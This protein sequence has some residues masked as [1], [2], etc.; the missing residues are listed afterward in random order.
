[1][2]VSTFH[3][4]FPVS[5]GPNLIAGSASGTAGYSNDTNSAS[6]FNTP[7]GIVRDGAGNAYVADQSNHAIRKITPFGVVTTF[8]GTGSG[9]FVNGNGTSA[10]FSN[11]VALAIDSASNIYVADSS[12]NA[13]RKIDS[14]ANVTTMSFVVTGPSA[15]SVSS[16][17][18]NALTIDSGSNI[19][20][21]AGGSDYGALPFAGSGNSFPLAQSVGV[22]TDGIFYYGPA[23]GQG[24]NIT[25]LYRITLGTPTV[26][27]SSGVS[28]VSVSYMFGTTYRVT[29]N[30]SNAW[31]AVTSPFTGTISGFVSGSPDFSV[32]N[33]ISTTITDLAGYKTNWSIDYSFGS[34]P[35]S[36]TYIS[37]PN[38]SK[39]TT[40]TITTSFNGV[41]LDGT[42]YGTSVGSIFFYSPTQMYLSTS[43]GGGSPIKSYTLTGD[44]AVSNAAPTSAGGPYFIIKSVQ[45]NE[46]FST[47]TSSNQIV[48]YSNQ[49]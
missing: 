36:G 6:R 38:N 26:Q 46:Y 40:S 32:Y 45:G 33:G 9:G 30:L 31:S 18:S 44:T 49:Y 29:F 47:Y 10:S 7:R 16:D 21:Y 35:A 39:L 43:G 5:T 14:G 28:S 22:R 15:I 11:P 41:T 34:A 42:S 4:N 37:K 25:N 20:V 19:R 23:P 24:T 2:L 1:M 27:N 48:S 12:N 3:K 8:A 17:G 13:I